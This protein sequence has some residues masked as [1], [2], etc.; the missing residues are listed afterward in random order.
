MKRNLRKSSAVA[1]AL[2]GRRR[3]NA[4]HRLRPRACGRWMPGASRCASSGLV[5]V[6]AG[7]AQTIKYS[8]VQQRA[9]AGCPIVMLLATLVG[10][11]DAPEVGYRGA[12]RPAPHA[13]SSPSTPSSTRISTSGSETPPA[14]S[15][16]DRSPASRWP[17]SRARHGP[18][19]PPDALD[20]ACRP[21][22]AASSRPLAPDWDQLPGYQQKRLMSAARQYPKMLPIQQERFQERIRDWAA[23]TP[24]QRKAAR[25][26]FQGLQKLPAREAARAARAL[27]RGRRPRSAA[28][29]PS[30]SAA[31]WR[32]PNAGAA[33]GIAR[34]ARAA[35]PTNCSS[36]RRSSWS[37]R[38]PFLAFAGDSTQR[39]APPPAA[40]LGP[41]RRRRVLRLVLDPRRADARHEDLA[42]PPRTR[43][44]AA[45]RA[46]RARSIAT[47]LPLA[48]RS[49]R[50]DSDSSGR[51]STATA[52]SSTTGSRARASSRRAA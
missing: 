5:T 46:R 36:S 34:A 16:G 6:G 33:P 45:R 15:S 48:R 9:A 10:E 38:F 47:S 17:P 11:V 19:D 39:L 32:A 24:E 12:R 20:A 49:P 14:P 21:R 52:S 37:P 41:A 27:A 18:E 7:T 29:A 40:G 23:M 30:P 43:P 13:A 8:I 35:P 44:T 31:E 25:E 28:R 1:R 51:S 2:G 4:G 26:T 22:T 3:R 50:W 42:H